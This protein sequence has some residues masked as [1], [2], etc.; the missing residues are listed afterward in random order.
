MM[1]TLLLLY[2]FVS[3]CWTRTTGEGKTHLL[4]KGTYIRLCSDVACLKSFVLKQEKS[5]G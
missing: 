1:T 2:R 4:L 3:K 5:F